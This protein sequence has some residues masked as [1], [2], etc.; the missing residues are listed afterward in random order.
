MKVFYPTL[1]LTLLLGCN[2][3]STYFY[4]ESQ[5][6]TIDAY[7]QEGFY[8]YASSLNDSMLN[9]LNNYDK[10]I[11]NPSMINTV[12]TLSAKINKERNIMG[13]YI[14]PWKSDFN[15]PISNDIIM[16]EWNS[17]TGVIIRMFTKS[18]QIIEILPSQSF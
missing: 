11:L 17:N 10:T 2:L 9:I 12:K 1:F 3:K 6:K 13:C 18:S 4:S 7:R 14:I 5:S 15:K 8:E 16:M